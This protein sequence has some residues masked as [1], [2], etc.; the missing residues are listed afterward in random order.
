MRDSRHQG[1]PCPTFSRCSDSFSVFQVD[2]ALPLLPASCMHFFALG[3]T[4]RLA[5][6]TFSSD[7]ASMEEYCRH[8]HR[9]V[10]CDWRERGSKEAVRRRTPL[11]LC[12]RAGCVL[13]QWS[14]WACAN[15]CTCSTT[16]HECVEFESFIPAAAAGLVAAPPAEA[17]TSLVR[18]EAD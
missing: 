13:E 2:A 7:E 11:R 6:P 5:C 16:T 9:R 17:R 10:G 4:V 8:C 15:A 14:T 1:T 3:Q 18:A 12:C